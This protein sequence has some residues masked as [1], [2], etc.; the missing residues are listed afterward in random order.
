[1][2]YRAAKTPEVRLLKVPT[3]CDKCNKCHEINPLPAVSQCTDTRSTHSHADWM[4][5]DSVDLIL[6]DQFNVARIALQCCGTERT[7]SLEAMATV[8]YCHLREIPAT[9]THV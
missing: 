7:S 1:M 2:L 6:K 8:R 4:I 5:R 9:A 3:Q